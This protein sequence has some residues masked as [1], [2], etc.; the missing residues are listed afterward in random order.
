[1]HLL[2]EKDIISTDAVQRLVEM[3]KCI[4]ILEQQFSIAIKNPQSLILQGSEDN[5]ETAD[6][7][8]RTLTPSRA[9]DFE[10][11]ASAIPPHPLS[12]VDNSIT[13][14]FVFQV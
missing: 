11:A 1:M 10:S 6:R 3:D 7:G 2:E 9:A 8:T 12:D 13:I 14:D 4:K 5:T